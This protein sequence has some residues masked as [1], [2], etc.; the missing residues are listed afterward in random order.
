L[1]I[2]LLVM[3]FISL[4]DMLF[5]PLLPWGEYPARGRKI[6]VTGRFA[7]ANRQFSGFWK[8]GWSAIRVYFKAKTP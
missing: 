8:E 7:P 5:V 3:N 6:S 2:S 4:F 1:E